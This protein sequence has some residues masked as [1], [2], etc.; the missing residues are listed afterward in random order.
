MD[1]EPWESAI[2][3][4]GSVWLL[5]R[6]YDAGSPT[7][8]SALQQDFAKQLWF[9]YRMDFPQIGGFDTD[10][11]WGCMHRAGQVPRAALL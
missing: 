3:R 10:A 9:S 6:N 1:G 4:Q 11:G 7:S 2:G 5:G 8:M